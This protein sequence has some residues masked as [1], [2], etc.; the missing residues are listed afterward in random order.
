MKSLEADGLE[1]TAESADPMQYPD[2]RSNRKTIKIN[3][4]I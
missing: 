3:L 1:T 4:V 2:N